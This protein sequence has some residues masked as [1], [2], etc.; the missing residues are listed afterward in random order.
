MQILDKPHMWPHPD[1]ALQ[2]TG[3]MQICCLHE[4]T[5]EM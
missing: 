5:L 3:I 4:Y 1:A 2:Y